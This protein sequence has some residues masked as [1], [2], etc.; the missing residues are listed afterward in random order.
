MVPSMGNLIDHVGPGCNHGDVRR[1][2]RQ[3]V[4]PMLRR[5]GARLAYPVAVGG[6]GLL[7]QTPAESS[8]PFIS[9]HNPSVMYAVYGVAIAIATVMLFK[10]L[11]ITQPRLRRAVG[12]RRR[13]AH[14]LRT[15]ANAEQRARAMMSEL[16]PHGWRAQIT[17]FGPGD[18]MPPDAPDGDRSRV[19]LDWAELED[20]RRRVAVVRRVWAPTIGEALEAM[21]ADRRTDE[22]L[23][24]IEQGALADADGTLWPDL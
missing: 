16:C 7:V 17:L 24:Q 18:E 14:R 13:R 23:E 20:E 3:S 6:T 22:T 19:A 5:A 15:A 12:A 21:I 2:V 11:A 8:R 1:R 10:M 4:V 9:G